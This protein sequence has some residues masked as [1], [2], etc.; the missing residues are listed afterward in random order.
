MP[1]G[2]R[3]VRGAF[4]GLLMTGLAMVLGIANSVLLGRVLGPEGYGLYSF[5]MILVGMVSVPFWY[6]MTILLTREAGRVVATGTQADM[7]VLLAWCYGWTLRI[8]LI[9]TISAALAL[10][11]FGDLLGPQ[12]LAVCLA[13]LPMIGLSMLMPVS[14]TLLRGVGGLVRSQFCD[15]VAR[16]S[17]SLLAVLVLLAVFAHTGLGAS[18]ALVA[19]STAIAGATLLSSYWLMLGWREL[20]TASKSPAITYTGRFRFRSLIAFSTFATLGSGFA[21][22]D[23]LFLTTIE[24]NTA[25][26][27]Y[28]IAM[29]G[30]QLVTSLTA[31]IN[32][33]VQ[34]S[35]ASLY[36]AGDHGRL[37]RLL[38][39]NA[40]A[41]LLMAALPV[42]I[43]AV[44]A[45]PL[46]RLGFGSA[47]AAGAQALA[48]AALG[49]LLVS[50]AGPVTNLLTMTGNERTAIACLLAG[51]V[52][53]VVL[54]TVLIPRFGM[55]GAA[56]ATTAGGLLWTVLMSLSER[57]L[58]GLTSS[59]FGAR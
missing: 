15:L 48:I 33:T 17:L 40:R 2:R 41:T 18:G 4:A 16:P 58:T 10:W 28:R 14:S 52:L 5:A 25:L 38:T 45:E 29:I 26:G 8:A 44:F 22:V 12:R 23:S 36:A 13:A 43:L 39:A 59:V 19:Q 6:G 20:P 27:I 37:Q 54:C 47:Y 51:I 46:L 56:V 53:N 35:I 32:I 42:T 24:G 31:A 3:L 49:Q 11:M 57:R 50:L 30:V 1:L 21:A 9:V 7:G 55:S 34:P